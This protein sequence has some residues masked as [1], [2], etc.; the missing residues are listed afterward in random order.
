MKRIDGAHHTNLT[1]QHKPY[2]LTDEGFNVIWNESLKIDVTLGW[3]LFWGSCRAQGNAI[4]TVTDYKLDHDDLSWFSYKISHNTGTVL[5]LQELWHDGSRHRDAYHT[6][7]N[8]SHG[9]TYRK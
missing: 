6:T 5:L 2:L 9:Y 4:F 1:N 8:P 7:A 3:V